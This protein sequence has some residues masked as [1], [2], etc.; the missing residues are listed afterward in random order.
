M[1]WLWIILPICIVA[2]LLLLIPLFIRRIKIPSKGERGEQY[3]AKLLTDCM[4]GGDKLINNVIVVNPENGMSSQIDHILFSTRGIFVVE[5]KNHSGDIYGND[6][7]R[8]WKQVLGRTVNFLPSP[9]RQNETHIYVLKKIL[10]TRAWLEN[11]VVFA[12]GNTHCIES[13]FV[14]TP[15]QLY[16]YLNEKTE[17]PVSEKERD[18]LYNIVLRCKENPA[19][20]EKQH[21]RNI[22][23]MQER[24]A[25][26]LCPRCNGRLVL[27]NG[28]HGAFFG[29]SN[30]PKCT[31]T[32]DD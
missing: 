6:V 1:E 25:N 10:K 26:N 5:T 19:V 12:Q 17:R 23:D 7:T 24:I 29:C 2:L 20:T 3:I 8:Q 18:R 32:K 21:N 4:R 30:Y 13:E 28:V 16:A 14:Y 31:F 22:H 9:V 15:Q 27:R 11:I